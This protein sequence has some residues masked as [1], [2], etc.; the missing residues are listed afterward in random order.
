MLALSARYFAPP[1]DAP[2]ALLSDSSA[3]QMENKF[4]KEAFEKEQFRRKVSAAPVR[5]VALTPLLG[6]STVNPYLISCLVTY[7]PSCTNIACFSIAKIK[8]RNCIERLVTIRMSSC[9]LIS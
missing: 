3:L 8:S 4:V 9:L 1:H 6:R 7:T 5:M 2:S